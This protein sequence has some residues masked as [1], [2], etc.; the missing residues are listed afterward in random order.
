M[1][2]RMHGVPN[3]SPNPLIYIFM[4]D[5]SYYTLYPINQIN[6]DIGKSKCCGLRRFLYRVCSEDYVFCSA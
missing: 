6:S 1:E 2:W 5:D 4:I 3:E